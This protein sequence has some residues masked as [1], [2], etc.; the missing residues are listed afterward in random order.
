MEMLEVKESNFAETV[1]R[2]GIV[3]VDCWA[4]WCGACKQFSPVYES[5]A[6]RYPEYL[7]ATLETDSE[8]KLTF[9]LGITEI[10]TLMVFRDGI[11]VFCQPGNYTEDGLVDIIEQARALDMEMVK[12]EMVANETAVDS[13]ETGL[14]AQGCH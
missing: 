4:T 8:T 11:P 2:D 6:Q 7:F 1:S 10:P 12:R 14:V 5:V 3:V 13:L 9:D